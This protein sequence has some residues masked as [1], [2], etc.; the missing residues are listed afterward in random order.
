MIASD[1]IDTLAAEVPQDR[2]HIWAIQ[3]CEPNEKQRAAS[4]LARA[5]SEFSDIIKMARED[6]Q[7]RTVFDALADNTESTLPAMQD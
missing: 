2:R 1:L 4:A 7:F 6:A 5:R 3:I